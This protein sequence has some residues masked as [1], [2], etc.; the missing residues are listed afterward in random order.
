MSSARQFVLAV[1]LDGVV[2]DLLGALREFLVRERGFDKERLGEPH[3]Y[4]FWREWGVH[5]PE[6][7][8][9]LHRDAVTAGR[10]FVAA[11]P[12]PG[13]VEALRL[14]SDE[15]VHLRIVTHRFWIGGTHKVAA[16]DTVEWLDA[17]DVPY[18]SICFIADKGAVSADLYVDD[19]PGTVSELRGS[20]L[21]AVLFDAPYN[22]A[23]PHPRV[24]GWAELT[25]NLLAGSATKKSADESEFSPRTAGRARTP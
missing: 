1:D 20:G 16:S 19:S 13:A 4:D 12:V 17:H 15:D 18:R 5:D 8:R 21:D 3:S 24:S 6:Q 22:R 9:Q 23:S 14:L 2:V 11:R 25:R 7:S 10:V